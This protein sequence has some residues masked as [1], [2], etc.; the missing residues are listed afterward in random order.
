MNIILF[1]LIFAVNKETGNRRIQLL[2]AIVFRELKQNWW[3]RS[4]QTVE[5]KLPKCRPPN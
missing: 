1:L 2:V 4:T 3:W 5:S